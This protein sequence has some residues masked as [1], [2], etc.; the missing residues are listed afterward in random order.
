MACGAQVSLTRPTAN[1]K[2]QVSAH[3]I[4]W[5]RDAETVLIEM[6]RENPC[7]WD[8]Q[9]PDFKKKNLRRSLFSALA[10]QLA[11]VFPC[12]G[13]LTAGKTKALT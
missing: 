12:L 13:T 7:L 9:H 4:P 11:Q 8:P 3:R 10:L 5:T 1:S 2:Q 6:V